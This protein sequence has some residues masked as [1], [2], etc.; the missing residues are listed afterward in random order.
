[1]GF[2]HLTGYQTILCDAGFIFA[3]QAPFTQIK[4]QYITPNVLKRVLN[5]KEGYYKLY[6]E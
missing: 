2:D 4:F 5:Y 3:A 1:M 6:A